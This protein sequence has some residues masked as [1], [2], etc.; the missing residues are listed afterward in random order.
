[1]AGWKDNWSVVTGDAAS[2]SGGGQADTMLVCRK[3]DKRQGYLKLLRNN[4]DVA[5]RNR[6]CAECIALGNLESL[7]FVPILMEDNSDQYKTKSKLYLV[8]EFVPGPT[9]S[10]YLSKRSVKLEEAVTF[11]IEL[12]ERVS[13]AHDL[14]AIHRDLKPDNIVLRG[15][16]LFDPVLVDFGLS[17][18]QDP[19]DFSSD[20]KEKIQ[21]RFLSLP[22]LTVSTSDKRDPR[23]DFTAICGIFFHMIFGEPPEALRDDHD[24]KPH[25]RPNIQNSQYRENAAI[26]AFLDRSFQWKLENRWQSLNSLVDAL[27]SL[28]SSDNGKTSVERLGALADRVNS[29]SDMGQV[30]MFYSIAGLWHQFVLRVT[31][32]TLMTLPNVPFKLATYVDRD[33]ENL[34]GQTV[35]RVMRKDRKNDQVRL[36]AHFEL[37]GN[38]VAFSFSRDGST[39]NLQLGRL[40]AD[41]K[42]DFGSIQD[43]LQSTF[44]Q[45]IVEGFSEKL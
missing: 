34:V 40:P 21:N 14:G 27:R 33:V 9:L 13:A 45:Q 11:S 17:F 8:M 44:S 36:R 29:Q 15:G 24:L 43:A 2:S 1:M 3:S 20:P 6:F 10:Q 18:N 31:N 41:A 26:S 19:T 4:S 22:E 32:S 38:E 28:V 7:S 39:T 12:A 42:M 5:R 25:Q 35:I 23:S 16:T 30:S 37:L